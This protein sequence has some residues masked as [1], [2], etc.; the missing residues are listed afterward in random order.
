MSILA[1]RLLELNALPEPHGALSEHLIR[2]MAAELIGEG[3]PPASAAVY[4]F[5]AESRVRDEV[6]YFGRHGLTNEEATR[7][8]RWTAKRPLLC[9]AVLASAPIIVEILCRVAS[10]LGAR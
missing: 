9:L 5:T 4:Q 7:H 8:A 10:W 2:E 1:K 3:V 6:E